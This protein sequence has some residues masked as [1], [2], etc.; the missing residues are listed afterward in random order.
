[1]NRIEINYFDLED[2]AEML[3]LPIH[4][5]YIKNE[6]GK[7]FARYYIDLDGIDQISS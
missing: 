2:I 1:M 3:G 5:E 7:V 4:T 6:Q